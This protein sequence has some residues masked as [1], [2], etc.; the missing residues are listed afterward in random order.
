MRIAAIVVTFHPN[1]NALVDNILTYQEYVDYIL[2]W[3]NSQEEIKIPESVQAKIIFLCVVI[4]VLT[5]VN[6]N[7]NHLAV[8]DFFVW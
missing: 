8:L 7:R 6:Q 5:Y 2:I 1:I 4:N 3:R